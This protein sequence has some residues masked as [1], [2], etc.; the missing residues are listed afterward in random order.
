MWLL[1]IMYWYGVI[2]YCRKFTPRV[3]SLEHESNRTAYKYVL[4][5]R[6]S[7]LTKKSLDP[8]KPSELP[9]SQEEKLSQRFVSATYT[10]INLFNILL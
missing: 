6:H 5:G 4:Q 2:N 9:P 7:F 8:S 1:I 3:V 10:Y